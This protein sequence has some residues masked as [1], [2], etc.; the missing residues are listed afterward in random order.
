MGKRMTFSDGGDEYSQE[1]KQEKPPDGIESIFVASFPKLAGQTM[2]EFGDGKLLDP[3]TMLMSVG[4]DIWIFST[5][6]PA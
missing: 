3:E 6:Y 5:H 4:L 2:E 1:T